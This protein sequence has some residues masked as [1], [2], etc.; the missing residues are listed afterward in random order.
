MNLQCE[1]CKGQLKPN[2]EKILL[3]M[4]SASGLALIGY[5][6]LQIGTAGMATVPILIGLGIRKALFKSAKRSASGGFFV[7]ARC[8]KD[9]T[10]KHVFSELA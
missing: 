5:I 8:R 1:Y 7:C 10:L 2:R 9:A 4:G 6:T 3:E